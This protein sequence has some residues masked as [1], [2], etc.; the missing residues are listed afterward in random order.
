MSNH[1]PGISDREWREELNG[2]EASPNTCENYCDIEH[3]RD[4]WLE[5]AN[6]WMC[7]DCIIDYFA[8]ELGYL[9]ELKDDQDLGDINI[10]LICDEFDIFTHFYVSGFPEG[11]R[12]HAVYRLHQL[13]FATKMMQG[14]V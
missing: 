10:E 8:D 5:S 1:P 2:A 14:S 7:S 4:A 9:A 11:W 13:E 6:M 3:A 12:G